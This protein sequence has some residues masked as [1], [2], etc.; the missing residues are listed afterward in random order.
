VGPVV[1]RSPDRGTWPDRRAPRG[2]GRPAVG[3]SGPVGRPGHNTG[4]DHNTGSSEALVEPMPTPALFARLAVQHLGQR[5]LRAVLLALAVAVGGGA[6]FSAAVLR[7][8]IQDSMGVSL[9]RL[10]ADLM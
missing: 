5:P 4:P 1:P 3:L 2:S 10:G 9:S 7:R 8:A 6:L